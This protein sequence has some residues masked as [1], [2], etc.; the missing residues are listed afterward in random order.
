MKKTANIQQIKDD[1]NLMLASGNYSLMEK[2]G[3]CA[4]MD[5]ILQSNN[6]YK[7]FY[8]FGNNETIDTTLRLEQVPEGN[9]L[10]TIWHYGANYFDRHYI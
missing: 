8:Y 10:T 5:K 3:I 9:H 7:G 6:S 4:L 2:S 1:C